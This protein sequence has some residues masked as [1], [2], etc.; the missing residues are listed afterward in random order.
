MRIGLVVNPVAGLGGRVGL[1]GTDGPDTVAEALRRGAVPEAGARARRALALLA[2]RA[3]GTAIAAPAGELG[4]HWL[5]GLALTVVPT[6][7]ARPSGTARDTREAVAAMA[8]R[9]L[10]VFAGGDGTARDVAGQLAADQ[11]MLGI[12]CW[13]EDAFRCLRRLARGGRRPARRSADG[14]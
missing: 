1:K 7:P 4:A 2:Q 9:D 3:P 14:P 13:R 8:D 12:P 10:V 6:A 5:E 11:A